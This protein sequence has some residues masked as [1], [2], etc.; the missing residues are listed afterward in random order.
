MPLGEPGKPA[1]LPHC[2][3]CEKPAV[4]MAW[5]VNVCGECMKAWHEDGRFEAGRVMEALG[6]EALKALDFVQRYAREATLRMRAWV[7]ERRQEVRRG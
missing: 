4:W 1:T 6:P 3:I 7:A 5:G 2:A